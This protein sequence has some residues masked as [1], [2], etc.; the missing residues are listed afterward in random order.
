MSGNAAPDPMMTPTPVCVLAQVVDSGLEQGP[1][2]FETTGVV[3][4][5]EDLK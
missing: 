5:V 1:S 4:Y 2:D 3:D